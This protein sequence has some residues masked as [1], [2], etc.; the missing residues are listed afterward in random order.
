MP[1]AKVYIQVSAEDKPEEAHKGETPPR[2]STGHARK[3]FQEGR[4]VERPLIS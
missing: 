1:H 4:G 2:P 3:E